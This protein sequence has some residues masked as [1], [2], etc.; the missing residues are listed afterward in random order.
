MKVAED[1]WKSIETKS[2][3]MGLVCLCAEEH[4]PLLL[5][6][7]ATN[8]IFTDVGIRG[9]VGHMALN[10]YISSNQRRYIKK[11]GDKKW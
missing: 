4:W 2:D 11:Q 9:V 1:I 8:T 10:S 6:G 3:R 5:I 7:I